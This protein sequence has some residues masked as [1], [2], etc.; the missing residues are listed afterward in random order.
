MNRKTQVGRFPTHLVNYERY[1]SIQSERKV[2]FC[3]D[4]FLPKT[5][6]LVYP[7]VYLDNNCQVRGFLKKAFIN[8]LFK[9]IPHFLCQEGLL[10]N[11]EGLSTLFE[12]F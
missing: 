1:Q 10:D 6:H 8:V 7:A 3:F 9:F 5:N 12:P 11:L 4:F 2:H